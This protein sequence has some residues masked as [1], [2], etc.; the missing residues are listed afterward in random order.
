MKKSLGSQTMAYPLPVWVI[1]S[2]D[3]EGK[4]N[5]ATVAWGG[6]CCS[7]PACVAISLRESRYTH[8][9]IV[10]Q[11]AFTVNVPSAEFAAE[12]D[13]FGTVSGRDQDKF[14]AT[15]LTAV[16]SELVNAPIIDEFPLVLECKL[17]FQHELGS[18]TQFVG[19]II[20]IKVEP[21]LLGKEGKPDIK[22]IDPV[23]YSTK[24]QKYYRVGD[25]IGRA[26]SIGR[27]FQANKSG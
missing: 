22:A 14:Q 3:L 15:G 12:A 16:R 1:G 18:H 17:L 26:Y 6:I 4:A 2:Y 20:D 24:S 19:E 8:S 10:E 13:Y 11:G 27:V 23:I 5:A 9:N 21:D 7:K 25:L